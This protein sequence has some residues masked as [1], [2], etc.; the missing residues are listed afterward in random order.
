MSAK[1]YIVCRASTFEDLMELVN[2]ALDAGYICQG[3]VMVCQGVNGQLF[4]QAMVSHSAY[5]N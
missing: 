1:K 2:Q 5:G 4:A 3:G